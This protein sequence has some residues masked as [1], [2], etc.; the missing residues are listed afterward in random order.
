MQLGYIR[1][2]LQEYGSNS[3]WLR[4]FLQAPRPWIPSR[5]SC[6]RSTAQEPLKATPR[7][8]SMN[9]LGVPKWRQK[10]YYVSYN[11]VPGNIPKCCRTLYRSSNHGASAITLKCMALACMVMEFVASISGKRTSWLTCLSRPRKCPW[12]ANLKYCKHPTPEI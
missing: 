8:P 2:M 6:R 1:D 7:S 11:M 12:T 9:V 3:G 4:R 5:T 10:V